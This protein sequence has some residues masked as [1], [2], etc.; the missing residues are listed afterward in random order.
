LTKGSTLEIPVLKEWYLEN[1]FEDEKLISRIK[2]IYSQKGFFATRKIIDG[3]KEAIENISKLYNVYILTSP[4]SF[5]VWS[6]E[7]K[8]DW[9]RYYFGNEFVHKKLGLNIKF[10]GLA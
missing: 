7:D 8:M 10:V 9:W 5:N 1:N 2:Q 4:A 3:A 6:F